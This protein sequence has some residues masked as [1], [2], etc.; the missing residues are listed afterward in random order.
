MLLI[1]TNLNYNESTQMLLKKTQM[2]TSCHI[3]QGR[4][5]ENLSLF[6]VH[7]S[8]FNNFEAIIVPGCIQCILELLAAMCL[9][10]RG[11]CYPP[12][13]DMVLSHRC[14]SPMCMCVCV[15]VC[16]GRV[17]VCV[18]VCGCVRV[19]AG[20]CVYVC[21]RMCKSV[22]VCVRVGEGRNKSREVIKVRVVR[23]LRNVRTV[24][25]HNKQQQL[26]SK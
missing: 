6:A 7:L 23:C 11:I 3:H 13:P 10:L 8:F 4:G 5:R 26:M 20:V 12:P 9:L 16:V 21:V 15:C 2:K 17:C 19:C 24:H 22:C 1:G 25:L 14:T 18:Y